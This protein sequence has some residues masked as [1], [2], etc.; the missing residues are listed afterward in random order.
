MVFSTFSVTGFIFLP[1]LQ[2][3]LY[4]WHLDYGQTIFSSSVFVSDQKFRLECCSSC[5]QSCLKDNY[6][7]CFIFIKNY[8][9]K[10]REGGPKI[11]LQPFQWELRSLGSSLA[12][13]FPQ[14]I[15]VSPEVS[16][17]F[18]EWQKLG[19]VL[20]RIPGS[21]SLTAQVSGSKC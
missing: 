4:F 11:F 12:L 13:I 15:I 18:T 5:L 9:R 14:A 16:I 7:R 6:L 20:G 2:F 8:S 17:W 21:P 10:G 1:F 3:C 19:N